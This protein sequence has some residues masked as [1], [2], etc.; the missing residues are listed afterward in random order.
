MKQNQKDETL[1]GG[2]FIKNYMS[3][4]NLLPQAV[5][6]TQPLL[7]SFRSAYGRY[8][9]DLEDKNEKKKKNEELQQL[10]NE[11]EALNK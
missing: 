6:I 11:S 9:Q 4:N 7:K 8:K 10:E 5:S 2:R 3:T 1:V